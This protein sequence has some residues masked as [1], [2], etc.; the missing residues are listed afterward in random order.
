MAS[1]KIEPLLFFGGDIFCLGSDLPKQRLAI[2]LAGVLQH[3]D[4]SGQSPVARL[5]IAITEYSLSRLGGREALNSLITKLVAQAQL[6]MSIEGWVTVADLPNHNAAEI[7]RAIGSPQPRSVIVVVDAAQFR[8]EVVKPFISEAGLGKP[9]LPEDFWVPQ[10]HALADEM[11]RTYKDQEVYYVLDAGE[12]APSRPKLLEML[13]SIDGVGLSVAVL[14]GDRN[15]TIAAKADQWTKWAADGQVGLALQDIDALP[16]LFNS[17]K[18]VLR[19]QLLHR[20]ELHGQALAEL[21]GIQVGDSTNP[22]AVTK[23]ARIASDAGAGVLAARLLKSAVPRLTKLED[24]ALALTI[25]SGLD[26]PAIERSV[27]ERLEWLFP[28]SATLKA[29]T[30]RREISC[31]NYAAAVAALATEES[32]DTIRALYEDVGRELATDGIVDYVGVRRRLVHRHAGLSDKIDEALIRDALR[33]RLIVHALE[34]AIKKPPLPRWRARLLLEIVESILLN[35]GP[36]NSLPVDEE[37][38]RDAVELGIAYLA[39]HPRDGQFRIWVARLLDHQ[40]AGPLGL[41]LIAV[42]CINAF[43][44]PI[45]PK[46]IAVQPSWSFESLAA[47]KEFLR[48]ANAWLASESQ[49]DL[50]Q[51]R[52]PAELLPAAASADELLPA[53]EEMLMGLGRKLDTQDDLQAF[54]SWLAI[55]V[56]VARI[57]S[58]PA[59]DLDMIGIAANLL[60]QS[61]RAQRARDLAEQALLSCGETPERQRSA[62]SIFGDV[63]RRT[64]NRVEALVAFTCCGMVGEEVALE[65]VWKETYALAGLFRDIGLF[66]QALNMIGKAAEILDQLGLR[67]ENQIQL[68]LFELQVALRLHLLS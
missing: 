9:T 5:T 16:T 55:G 23:L 38:I 36:A 29:R 53:L 50:G 57:S 66:D 27:V 39:I 60:A 30:V 13:K 10:L 7:N 68:D 51:I 4:E 58:D 62:W 37:R 43:R 45:I 11:R 24:L 41:A 18:P 21:A 63:Y 61:G 32:A 28:G 49:A 17:E 1:D 54:T 6:N 40:V 33:R 3:H 35:A 31:G 15:A 44:R 19:V 2:V 67:K 56:A 59:A 12:L 65:E 47:D 14:D 25:A 46:R 48:R 22:Y 52:F 42:L 8:S 20:A 26:N 34:M 64:E